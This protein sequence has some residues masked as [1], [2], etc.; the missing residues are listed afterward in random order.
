MTEVV[1]ASPG[2]VGRVG[3]MYNYFYI[4][5]MVMIHQNF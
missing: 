1:L 5:F 4:Y 3:R 2:F